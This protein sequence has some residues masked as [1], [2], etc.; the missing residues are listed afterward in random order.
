MRLWL[1]GDH[2][3]KVI[4]CLYYGIKILMIVSRRLHGG[5]FL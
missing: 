4:F 2:V 3:L 5:D 1:E